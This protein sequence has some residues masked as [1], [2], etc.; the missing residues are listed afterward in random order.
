[1]HLGQKMLRNLVVA[2]AFLYRLPNRVK[3]QKQTD[4]I[5]KILKTDLSIENKM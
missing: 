5:D 1:M 4:E 3:M 2:S